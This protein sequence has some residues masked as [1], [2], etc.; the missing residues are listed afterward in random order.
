MATQVKAT[1][2]EGQPTADSVPGTVTA[3]TGLHPQVN[4]IYPIVNE[5]FR[6]MTGRDDLQAVDTN[7]LVAM[8]HDV[9][10]LGFRDIWLNTLA[11]RI[12]LTIDGYR[13][14][15]SKYS[16]L[17]RDSIEWGAIVQKLTADMPDA[18]PDKTWD[19][20]LMDGQSV[21]QWIISN[22]KV[23]QRFFDKETPYSFFITTSTKLLKDAF[24]S[25]GAMA[26]FISQIFGKVRN[27]IEFT[28][29]ELARLAVANFICNLTA[30]RVFKLVTIYNNTHNA[31]LTPLSARYNPEFLRWMIGFINNISN[32]M[33]TM[34]VLYNEDGFDRFTTKEYQRLYMLSDVMTD[35]QTIVSWEAFNPQYVT[36]N[37]DILVP[38]WQ[39]SGTDVAQDWNTISTIKGTNDKK[40][41]VE[42]TNLIGILFDH[43]A[44][45]TFREEEDV[46]T[47]PV[48]AR[49]R[50][51]NTF[52]HERQLYFNDMSENG[53]AF[54][55]E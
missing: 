52:W 23:H 41:K 3:V 33:E 53:V 21:D 40:E 9:L 4:Q 18:V 47:T 11:R 25:E 28:L 7:S 6:E 12:G 54:V 49:A 10:R 5:V 46:L 26:S 27:R 43:D 55:L 35:L 45:G 39:G 31:T 44:I 14:Y 15:E 20:G 22:P 34:S 29:E 8:G 1:T 38:Y 32:K 50:Y 48:N 36:A 13:V 37:P 51:Y 42:I 30:P 16:V 2:I 19:I 17:N 24:L